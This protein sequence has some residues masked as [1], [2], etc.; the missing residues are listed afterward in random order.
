MCLS[1][2]FRLQWKFIFFKV[3]NRQKTVFK[4]VSETKYQTS[5]RSLNNKQ[6]NIQLLKAIL[7][8]ATDTFLLDVQTCINYFLV[9]LIHNGHISAVEYL[10]NL[11]VALRLW[12]GDVMCLAVTVAY[13]SSCHARSLSSTA[14]PMPSL[15]PLHAP[16]CKLWQHNDFNIHSDQEME[17]GRRN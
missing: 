10:L 15:M 12:F 8:Q 5:T 13:S 1:P 7:Q 17:N 2:L 6:K 4:Q 14:H 9:D 16:C 11:S 3:L